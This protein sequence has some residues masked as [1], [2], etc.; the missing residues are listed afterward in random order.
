MLCDQENLSLVENPK[1]NCD[2]FWKLEGQSLDVYWSDQT[3]SCTQC[4]QLK[5][6]PASGT[7]KEYIARARREVTL[8][9]V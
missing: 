1:T 7:S 3:L 4:H 9:M 8:L 5:P 6:L 2:R